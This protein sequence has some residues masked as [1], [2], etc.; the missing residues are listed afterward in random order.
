MSRRR[1]CCPAMAY[2]DQHSIDCITIA[3]EQPGAM[4]NA[5]GDVFYPDNAEDAAW[6]AKEEG[7]KFLV[8]TND[9]DKQADEI[10]PALGE[11]L[12]GML[13]GECGCGAFD[14]RAIVDQTAR[15]MVAAGWVKPQK[16]PRSRGVHR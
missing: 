2:G 11:L 4:A 7:A 8:T 12:D 15:A 13:P 3:R 9:R 1:V 16:V 10:E 14:G 5:A 6:F